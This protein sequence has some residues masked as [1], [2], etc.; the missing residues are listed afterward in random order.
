MHPAILHR[1]YGSLLKRAPVLGRAAWST[2]RTKSAIAIDVGLAGATKVSTAAEVQV[3]TQWTKLT[4][5]AGRV[6]ITAWL[7]G[8]CAVVFGMVILGGAT[9]LTHSGLSMVE[10]KPQQ[11]LPPMNDAEWEEEFAKYKQFP[12]YKELN[13]DMVTPPAARPLGDAKPAGAKRVQ[14]HLLVR[15]RAPPAGEGHRGAICR[16]GY[17]L[18]YERL[19]QGICGVVA[20]A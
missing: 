6:Q 14:A 1:C 7:F 3:G 5:E 2:I 13:P 16:A 8:S 17:I 9:R 11:L 10:W 4:T 15:V 20:V 18:W 12:E 19:H